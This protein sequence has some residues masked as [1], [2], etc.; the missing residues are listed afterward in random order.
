MCVR[1][2]GIDI[3]NVPA[4]RQS[5]PSVRLRSK[6]EG[7]E[8][9][10]TSRREVSHVKIM[11]VAV[12]KKHPISSCGV[13]YPKQYHQLTLREI[14]EEEEGASQYRLAAKL[15]EI[16]IQREKEAYKSRRASDD[17]SLNGW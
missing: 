15:A 14:V 9:C 7:Q 10:K 5:R 3:A 12:A 6:T 16:A 4:R 2:L 1:N 13:S 11:E 17:Y 8:P